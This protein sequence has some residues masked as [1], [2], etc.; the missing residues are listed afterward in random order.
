[1][2]FQWRL[3]VTSEDGTAKPTITVDGAV[4]SL[5]SFDV[6]PAGVCLEATLTVQPSAVSIAP[7]DIVTLETTDGTSG[8]QSRYRGMAV[9]APNPHSPDLATVRLVGL[10]QRFYERTLEARV[11]AGGDVAVMAHAAL[12]SMPR[13]VGTVLTTAFTN[14]GFQL[15][16]RYPNLESVGAFL[17]ALAETVGPFIVP[18]GETYTYS[19]TTYQAGE[20]V[21][22]VEWGVEANGSIVFRRPQRITRTESEA[23][24]GTQVEWAP[25]NAEEIANQVRLIYL[26]G[27]DESRVR[28]WTTDSD[29]NPQP[30]LWVPLSSVPVT[31]PSSER[32]AEHV[33]V[34][35]G[36]MDY[37]E[38]TGSIVVDG[39]V[40]GWSNPN[41]ALD[42]D[43]NTFAEQNNDLATRLQFGTLFPASVARQGGLWYIEYDRLHGDNR[44]Q[45][46]TQFMGA[47]MG[48]R[49]LVYDL[50]AGEE[51]D[52]RVRVALP[53]LPHVNADMS[54]TQYMTGNISIVQEA[55]YARVYM[56]QLFVPDV[57]TIGAPSVSLNLAQALIRDVA[58]TPARVSVNG[59]QGIAARMNVNTASGS[60]ITG[61]RVERIEYR[62]TTGEGARTTYHTGLTFDAELESQRIVLERLARKAVRS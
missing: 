18:A 6:T 55:P 47:G 29:S 17:D 2:S 42:G 16:D 5:D 52:D 59:V 48:R 3:L 53:Q 56:V 33:R 4:A 62:I 23:T 49:R 35:E 12:N 22:G 24:P 28:G 19:L 10:K 11:I 7:R 38:P 51:P 14:T 20:R 1:M 13:P 40:V 57:N 27:I 30:P 15:G 39:A 46:I 54:L 43:P 37:M 21:P 60:S 8:W 34:L 41:N 50:D 9:I 26:S 31:A 61:L 58:P 36:P 32:A 45:L 44:K 25:A